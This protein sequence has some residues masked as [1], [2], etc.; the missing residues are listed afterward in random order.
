MESWQNLAAGL[1]SALQDAKQKMRKRSLALQF[2]YG[3]SD[4][5][6]GWMTDVGERTRSDVVGVNIMVRRN[7]PP[8]RVTVLGQGRK[9][10]FVECHLATDLDHTNH[11]LV[12]CLCLSN[13]IPLH[14]RLPRSAEQLR[15]RRFLLPEYVQQRQRELDVELES[16]CLSRESSFR[17]FAS[18]F[19]ETTSTIWNRRGASRS[20]AVDSDQDLVGAASNVALSCVLEVGVRVLLSLFSSAASTA[21]GGLA[22][23][24]S[25]LSLSMK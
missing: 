17:D 16:I 24:S 23:T 18:M 20:L 11:K 6:Y 4:H 25:S 13:P 1:L 5:A 3:A 21:S 9:H 7:A 2:G 22:E 14:L 10:L 12:V 19:R 15:P 8:R